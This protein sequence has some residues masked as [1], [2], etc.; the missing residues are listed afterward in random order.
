MSIKSKK[1]TLIFLFIISIFLLI[2]TLRLENSGEISA[3]REINDIQESISYKIDKL[4]IDVNHVVKDDE[5]EY[6]IENVHGLFFKI[7][8]GW[9]II[10]PLS[11]NA[12]F[13]HV[14]AKHAF[15]CNRPFFFVY[16]K[17]VSDKNFI[18]YFDYDRGLTSINKK[19]IHLPSLFLGG[20]I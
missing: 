17:K 14:N 18:I 13:S 2:V 4:R 5:G 15:L 12:E 1:N 16:T 7:F 3:Q 10:I 20:I 6:L 11:C 8:S 9:S 19:E